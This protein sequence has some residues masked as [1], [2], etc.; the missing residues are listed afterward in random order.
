MLIPTGVEN[1]VLNKN[2]CIY[3]NL[4]YQFT[5]YFTLQHNALAFKLLQ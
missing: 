4:V 1:L 2:R 3:Y 5:L